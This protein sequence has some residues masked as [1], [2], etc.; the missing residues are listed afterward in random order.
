MRKRRAESVG[1][2]RSELENLISEYGM[3]VTPL[4][5]LR[6]SAKFDWEP[7]YILYYYDRM[8]ISDMDE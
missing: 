8:M 3:E 1:N 7:D 2:L 5:T 4:G 6:G